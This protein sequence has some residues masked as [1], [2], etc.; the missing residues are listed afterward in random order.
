[1][2]RIPGDRLVGRGKVL[3]A[4]GMYKEAAMVF[5]NA[6]AIDGAVHEPLIYLACLVKAGDTGRAARL[7]S[8][9][10]DEDVKGVTSEA[11]PRIADLSAA[12]WLSGD[13]PPPASSLAK[14]H[15]AA[16]KAL[17]AWSGGADAEEVDAL[18]A[19]IPLRSPFKPLRLVLKSLTGTEDPERRRKLLDMIPP[20]SAF[21]SLAHAAGLAIGGDLKI[22]V[23]QGESR[24]AQENIQIGE[25]RVVGLSR[26][27]PGNEIVVDL[28]LDRDG[29]LQVT[30]REKRTGLQQRIVIDQAIAR[31][32]EAGMAEARERV[33]SLFGPAKGNGAGSGTGDGVPLNVAEL[34]ARAEAKLDDAGEEDRAELIDLIEAIRDARKACDSARLTASCEQLSDLIFYLET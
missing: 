34:L 24:D 31:L 25:F 16:E 8:R 9:F 32:G 29:I 15:D 10:L 21:E 23:F 14:V 11:L 33:G 7:C 17:A 12:L 4:K 2:A 28:A 30:A 1:M 26:S 27:P 20:D 13:H 22:N 6:T 18:L 3:A 5:D 19:A